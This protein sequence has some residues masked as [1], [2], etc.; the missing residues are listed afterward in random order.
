VLVHKICSVWEGRCGE[1]VYMSYRATK[2]DRRDSLTYQ[3]NAITRPRVPCSKLFAFDSLGSCDEFIR[4]SRSINLWSYAVLLCLAKKADKLET[5]SFSLDWTFWKD[6]QG[7]AE[8]PEGTVACPSLTPIRVERFH[9]G[10]TP[11]IFN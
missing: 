5:V 8:A 9:R 1:D 3:M 2:F 7:D 4:L 10:V 6:L 11:C